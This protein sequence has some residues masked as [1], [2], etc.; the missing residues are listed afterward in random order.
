MTET[1]A[2]KLQ[3]VQNYTVYNHRRTLFSQT[4]FGRTFMAAFDL[5][6]YML[7]YS[8]D[9]KLQCTGTFVY[10]LFGNQRTIPVFNFI[11]SV[12]YS[13]SW[14]NQYRGNWGFNVYISL[15]PPVSFIGF[16]FRFNVNYVID[17][18]VNFNAGGANPYQVTV[19][20]LAT[21]R[22]DTDASAGVRVVAIEGGAFITGTLVNAGTDPRVALTYYFNQRY[23]NVMARWDFWVN[24]FRY[25]WGFYYRTYSFWSGWS[26]RRV[27]NQWTINGVY[28]RWVIVNRNWNIYI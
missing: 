15:P 21:T 28:G 26:S 14:S 18:N 27:I 20:C 10:E 4:I 11:R 2:R 22:V 16:T 5:Q 9:Q 19:N 25:N 23:I 12:S 1:S 3:T 8:N 17:V 7:V 13:W 24:A 6:C